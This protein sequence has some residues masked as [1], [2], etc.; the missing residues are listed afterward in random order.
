MTDQDT[1]L[2]D[3]RF[4]VKVE[5]CDVEFIETGKQMAERLKDQD[6]EWSDY[7]VG[8]ESNPFDPQ[9]CGVNA[10]VM[11]LNLGDGFTWGC[12]DGIGYSTR[13]R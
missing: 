2:E 4:R 8:D 6:I 5:H 7:V 1:Q 10:L 9:T 11:S 3:L 12:G 13:T